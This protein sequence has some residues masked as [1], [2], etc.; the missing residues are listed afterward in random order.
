M[1]VRELIDILE[2]CDE[3]MEVRIGMQQRYGS[4]FAKTIR[5]VEVRSIKSFWGKDYEALVI[6]EDDQCGVVEYDTELEDW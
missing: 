4:D 1:T 6:T 3:D 2:C 5:D